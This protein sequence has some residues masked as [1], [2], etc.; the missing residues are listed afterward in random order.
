MPA[1]KK[2]H[3][4]SKSKPTR[5]TK[6]VLPVPQGFH[7]VTPHLVLPDPAKAIAFYSRAFGAKELARHEAPGGG[8]IMH[9]EIRI[10]DSIVMLSGECPGSGCKSPA[11][12]GGTP[13]TLNL[14]VPDADSVFHR[15]VSAGATVKMPLMDAF[16]G[17]RY[18]QLTDPFG[19]AWS[20]ATHKEDLSEEEIARRAET[21]FSQAPAHAGEPV[22]ARN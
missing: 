6:A 1:K 9:A 18:G 22:A 4:Q 8:G 12:L 17:D 15:A 14:Y 16:W 21:A 2:T 19:Y 3:A 5:K 13:V 20:V 7:T 10:G 11:A